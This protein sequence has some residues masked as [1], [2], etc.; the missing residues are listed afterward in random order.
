MLMQTYIVSADD[1]TNNPLLTV[2]GVAAGDTLEYSITPAAA[3]VADVE[4]SDSQ[5][6]TGEA[7]ADVENSTT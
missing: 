2:F 4:N 6:D 5:N 7:Q 3:P 1:I